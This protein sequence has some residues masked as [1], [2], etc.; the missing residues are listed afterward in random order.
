MHSYEKQS[1]ILFSHTNIHFHVELSVLMS[2]ISQPLPLYRFRPASRFRFQQNLPLPPFPLPVAA[3]ATLV[4]RHG[5]SFDSFNYFQLIDLAI[6][7]FLKCFEVQEICSRF[8]SGDY[9]QGLGLNL[10]VFFQFATKNLAKG[11]FL[12]GH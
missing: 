8:I 9:F 11:T 10:N 2:K 6:K 5:N 12:R 3:S 7:I 4:W 1:K